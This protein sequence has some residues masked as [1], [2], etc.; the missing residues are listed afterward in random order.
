MV[1]AAIAVG[2]L[3]FYASEANAQHCYVADKAEGAGAITPDDLFV[4][5]QSTNLIAPGGFID[6][7]SIGSPEDLILHGP[8]GG[9]IGYQGEGSL[10]QSAHEN[11]STTHGVLA[12]D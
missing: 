7:S 11:G 9:F 6:G 5:G 1:A 3:G 8:V 10:P 12:L 2:A 4:A